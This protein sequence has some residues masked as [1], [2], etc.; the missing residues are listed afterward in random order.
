MTTKEISTKGIFLKTLTRHSY[1]RKGLDI[2]YG[3]CTYIIF[4]LHDIR[5]TGEDGV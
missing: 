1:Y 2:T 3:Y 5:I 4:T